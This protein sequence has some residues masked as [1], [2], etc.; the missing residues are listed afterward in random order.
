MHGLYTELRSWCPLP[1]L[2][3]WCLDN[4]SCV[5][6]EKQLG[7]TKKNWHES[8]ESVRNKPNY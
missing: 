1:R 8:T 3:N 7:K 4:M 2:Q 5:N 6:W